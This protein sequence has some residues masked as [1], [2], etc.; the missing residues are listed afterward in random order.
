MDV[1]KLWEYVQAGGPP[2]ILLLLLALYWLNDERKTLKAERD[3]LQEQKDAL[4]ERVLSV[5][6]DGFTAVK[7]LR[8]LIYRGIE[9]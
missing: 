6:H 3:K 2:V 9:K 1:G 7:D 8:D 4:T 5:A